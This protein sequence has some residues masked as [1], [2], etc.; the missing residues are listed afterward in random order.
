M[1]ENRLIE[2]AGH[3]L[4]RMEAAGIPSATAQAVIEAAGAWPNWCKAWSEA[5]AR[6]AAISGEEAAG[7][8]VVETFEPGGTDAGRHIRALV[9]DGDEAIDARTEALL[10]A[11]D[12][13]QH[14]AEVV[15]PALA[16]GAWV[17]SDRHVPS[18]LA[19][20]GAARALGVD[21]LEELSAWATDGL[22]PDLVIVLDVPDDVAAGR[23]SAGDRMEREAEA[24]H[25]QVRAAYRSLAADRGWVVVDGSGDQDT[26][27]HRIWTVVSERLGP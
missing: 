7:R 9:L 18:S 26:V 16:R 6:H 10:M 14:V 27:E 11:A 17:V 20:Q 8:E 3:W 25:A 13:A 23:R 2:V 15:R 24:F 5:G 21:A 12:R 22:R 19:Y 4:P 1:T